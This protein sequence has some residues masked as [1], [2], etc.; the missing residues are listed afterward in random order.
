MA[1][2]VLRD[3]PLVRLMRR[4]Q[5][6][7][8]LSLAAWDLVLRQGRRAD[9]LARLHHLLCEAGVFDLVPEPV[10]R[11]LCAAEVVAQRHTLA[12]RREVQ[13]LRAA[14]TEIDVPLVLLKGA[15]Y[16]AAQLPV[17]AGRVFSDIDL[18]VP[19]DRLDD[20]EQVLMKHGWVSTQHDAYDQRYYRTWM[21]ELPPLTH[22]QRKSVLDVHHRILPATA[23]LQ[24][25]PRRLLAAARPAADGVYV[26]APA[27]MVLHSAT[28]LFHDGEFEHGLRDLFDLDGLIRYFGAHD[29]FWD[30]LLQS[31]QQLGLARPLYY[32]LRFCARL[33]DTPGAEWA[34]RE[35]RAH[36]PPRWQGAVMDALL[37][38]GLAP[39]HASCDTRLTPVAR[40]LLYVRAHYLRM[41]MRLLVPHLVRKACKREPAPAAPPQ[42]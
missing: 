25:D 7:A 6:A 42:P 23:R 26:L 8:Q 41:P 5:R 13:C 15:A 34:E 1:A 35:L 21:H 11:H 19:K 16:V 12:V 36:A 29:G 37:S 39:P 3:R 24:P 33:L 22:I 4:P 14:L 2:T 20:V 9:L 32:G 30:D 38:R 17:A 10:G 28:H 18:L 27:H 40:W 31:A